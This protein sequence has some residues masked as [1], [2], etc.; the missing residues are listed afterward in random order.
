MRIKVLETDTRLGI[1]AGEIYEGQRYGYDASK[2]SLIARVPDG[3]DPFCNLY[4]HEAA[5]WIKN[6]WM[7]IG[8]GGQYVPEIVE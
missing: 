4:M 3:Y 1:K 2:I 7:V 8:S 6:Q 5:Y